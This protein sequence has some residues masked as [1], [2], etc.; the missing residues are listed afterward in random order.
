VG[1]NGRP[2]GGDAHPDVE[3]PSEVAFVGGR[4]RLGEESPLRPAADRH[5]DIRSAVKALLSEF[6]SFPQA[7]FLLTESNTRSIHPSGSVRTSPL[8]PG[9]ALLSGFPAGRLAPVR[10]GYHRGESRHSP[11]HWRVWAAPPSTGSVDSSLVRT[12]AV[13]EFPVSLVRRTSFSFRSAP[14][15]DL[16]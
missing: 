1:S 4:S 5:R 3:C 10:S 13:S 14:A 7:R 6:D 11:A 9:Y 16:G 8:L 15:D 2:G 12:F